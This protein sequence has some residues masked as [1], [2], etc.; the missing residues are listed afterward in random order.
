ME[1][2]YIAN[3]EIIFREEQG[4]SILFNPDSGE[5]KILNETGSFIFRELNGKNSKNDILNKMQSV[6]DS[7]WDELEEDFNSF[8]DELAKTNMI[9]TL[10]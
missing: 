3:P 8:T 4:E 6:Y 2:N 9:F 10:T 5:V 1:K 7:S